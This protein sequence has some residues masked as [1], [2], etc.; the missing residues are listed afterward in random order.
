MRVSSWMAAVSV[1]QDTMVTYHSAQRALPESINRQLVLKNALTAK[2]ES[3]PQQKVPRP[4]PSVSCVPRWQTLIR[5]PPVQIPPHAHAV[6]VTCG[7]QY[8]QR[9]YHVRQ[10]RL[11]R[12]GKVSVRCASAGNNVLKKKNC[13]SALY[14]AHSFAI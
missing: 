10:A 11:C 9:V 4:K 5:R 1:K 14:S 12:R 7:T 3:I 2:R 6:G 13:K 8:L